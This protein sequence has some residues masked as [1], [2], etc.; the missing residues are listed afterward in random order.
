[1]IAAADEGAAGNLAEA[2]LSRKLAKFLKLLGWNV[3]ANGQVFR[4]RL[5]VLAE[6]E[7]VTAVVQQ[8]AERVEDLGVRLA[9]PQHEAA[10]GFD[11]GIQLLHASQ[12][13]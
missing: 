5:Q 12:H 10:L 11:L 7:E 9:E 4:R 3:A 8:I 2:Q 6:R 1:M 13:L